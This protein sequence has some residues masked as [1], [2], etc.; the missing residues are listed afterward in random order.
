MSLLSRCSIAPSNRLRA[1]ISLIASNFLKRPFTLE[2]FQQINVSGRNCLSNFDAFPVG[3]YYAAKRG[4]YLPSN[5]EW[6]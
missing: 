5:R 2:Q 1:S 6:A 4:Q 3:N